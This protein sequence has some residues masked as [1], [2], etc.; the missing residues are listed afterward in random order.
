MHYLLVTDGDYERAAAPK[1]SG[2]ECG[3]QVAQIQAQPM[4]ADCG[5]ELHQSPQV[6]AL[7]TTCGLASANIPQLPAERT[8][9][10]P[11]VRFDPYIGLANRRFRP[12]SHLSGCL[13]E[14]ELV[15]RRLG[16]A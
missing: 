15:P 2:A 1:K 5:R 11:A 14:G 7:P 10:E 13:G 16:F 6:A 4:A 12:L 8:G 3:A 9:F